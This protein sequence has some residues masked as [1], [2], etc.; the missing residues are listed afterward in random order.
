MKSE[1][2]EDEYVLEFTTARKLLNMT[3]CQLSVSFNEGQLEMW[4]SL[5]PNTFVFL[6]FFTKTSFYATITHSK[7]VFLLDFSKSE[8]GIEISLNDSDNAKRHIIVH[9][10]VENGLQVIRLL[11]ALEVVNHF[12]FYINL[13]IAKKLLLEPGAKT[14]TTEI[15]LFN[16]P[17]H[18]IFCIPGQSK[19]ATL[20]IDKP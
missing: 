15:S 16:G 6:P 8:E 10:I 5:M 9:T 7:Q 4:H 12:T 19:D 18:I 20:D 11:P 13:T 14:K 17:F 1:A 2:M 3:D